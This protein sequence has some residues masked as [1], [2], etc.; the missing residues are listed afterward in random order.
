M[1]AASCPNFPHG[2]IDDISSIAAIAKKHDIGFHVD[3]CLGSFLVAFMEK[4]GYS[5]PPFDFRVDGVTS[6]SVD[7]HKVT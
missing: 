5:L 7:T 2:I 4:A 3:C 1:I 6:I